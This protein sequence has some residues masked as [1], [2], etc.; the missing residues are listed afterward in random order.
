MLR[1][2]AAVETTVEDVEAVAQVILE[3]TLRCATENLNV[4]HRTAMGN[5]VGWQHKGEL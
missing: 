1:D 5:A 3:L 2:R 4:V